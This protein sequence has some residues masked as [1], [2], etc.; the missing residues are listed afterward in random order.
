MII[1]APVKIL[2]NI[3]QDCLSKIGPEYLSQIIIPLDLILIPKAQKPRGHK[4]G[5]FKEFVWK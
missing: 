5:K 3:T 2:V 1:S 4:E